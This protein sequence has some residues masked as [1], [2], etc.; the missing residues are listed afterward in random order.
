MSEDTIIDTKSNNVSKKVNSMT[1]VD[2]FEK[3]IEK[4]QEEI[5]PDLRYNNKM[6]L[7]MKYVLFGDITCE[8]DN[9]PYNL[10][11]AKK[12]LVN[13]TD[14]CSSPFHC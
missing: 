2:I 1:L 4:L 14:T 8:V 5:I 9:I 3:A 6:R 13:G 11:N 10:H 7:S 12:I